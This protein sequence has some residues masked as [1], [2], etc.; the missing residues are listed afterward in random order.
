MKRFV[1]FLFAIVSVVAM[2]AQTIVVTGVNVNLRMGPSL[3]ASTLVDSKTKR[4]IHP[5]KGERLPYLG[6]QGNFYKTRYAGYEVYISK[7]Y[8]RLEGTRSAS[9]GTTMVYVDGYHVLFRTGPS[10]RTACLTDGRGNPV[11]APQYGTL[12][13]LGEQGNFYKVIYSGKTLYITKDYTHL[14]TR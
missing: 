10:T 2:W 6:Q 12:T 7:D 11:Y 4:N 9:R 5:L 13:Y 8:T 14:V 3:S 1:I